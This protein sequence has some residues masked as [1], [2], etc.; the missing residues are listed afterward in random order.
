MD[1]SFSPKDEIWFLRVCHHISNAVYRSHSPTLKLRLSVY[2]FRR[3]NMTMVT[4]L[5]VNPQPLDLLQTF[6]HRP[7]ANDDPVSVLRGLIL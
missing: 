3:C 5:N 1:S 2:Q 4:V 6:V 7:T